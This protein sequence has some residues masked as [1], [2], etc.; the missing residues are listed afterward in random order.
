VTSALADLFD[1]VKAIFVNAVRLTVIPIV[2]SSL[3]VGIASIA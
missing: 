1:S 3:I 2:A